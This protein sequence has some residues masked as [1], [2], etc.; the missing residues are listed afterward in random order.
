MAS[1][2]PQ[3]PKVDS[4]LERSTLWPSEVAAL[5]KV[6]LATGLTEELKW[7]KPCYS[8]DGANIAIIQE[9]KAFV[10]L[11]FFKGALIAD[12]DDLLEEQGENSRSAKRMTFT[13]TAQVKRTAASIGTYVTAAIAAEQAGVTAPPP[14]PL[15]LADVIE[16]RIA[17]DKA[18]ATAFAGLTAGARR[19][20]NLHIAEAKQ[21][22]TRQAR[23]DKYVDRILAGRRMRDR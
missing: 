13:S 1:T 19:E 5:R 6:L 15:Q 11:M 12:P 22:A 20:Y 14:P 4:Y 23:L 21:I 7:G 17:N 9:M 10:A 8:V 2:N 18:F 3:H 16:Q